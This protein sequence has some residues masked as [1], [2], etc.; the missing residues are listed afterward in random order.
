MPSAY[1]VSL[2]EPKITKTNVMNGQWSQDG[3][4]TVRL[5]PGEGSISAELELPFRNATSPGQAR[6]QVLERL[7][8]GQRNG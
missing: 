2:D 8:G 6:Q 5:K 3:T 4:I 1:S 7:H